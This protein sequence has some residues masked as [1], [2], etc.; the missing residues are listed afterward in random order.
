M[1]TASDTP[2]PADIRL[3]R[4]AANLTQRQAAAL[5]GYSL[6]MWEEWESGRH[7]MR[8]VIWRAWNDAVANQ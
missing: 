2:D 5:V 7:P 8:P 3:A 4:L 1:A 6:R